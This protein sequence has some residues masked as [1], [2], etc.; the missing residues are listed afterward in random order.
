MKGA[1]NRIALVKSLGYSTEAVDKYNE[2]RNSP[3]KPT[4][5]NQK[6]G[7]IVDDILHGRKSI[8]SLI[9]D[10]TLKEEI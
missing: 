5:S 9:Y 2:V 6:T 10:K 3:F 4:K 1:K 8:N 7:D